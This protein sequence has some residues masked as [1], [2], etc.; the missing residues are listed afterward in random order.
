[1]ECGSTPWC[2]C[3]DI[4]IIVI[5]D[6]SLMR[7]LEYRGYKIYKCVNPRYVGY[8]CINENIKCKHISKK[9]CSINSKKPKFCREFPSEKEYVLFLPSKCPYSSANNIIKI[10][11]LELLHYDRQ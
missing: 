8:V 6:P 9:G 4:K 2:C 7:L 1:M 5:E 10:E 11:D 3:V